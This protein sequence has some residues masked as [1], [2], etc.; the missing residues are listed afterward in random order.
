MKEEAA[1]FIPQL[2]NKLHPVVAHPGKPGG[3]VI[4]CTLYVCPVMMAYAEDQVN[5]NEKCRA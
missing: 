5:T 4:G 1:K 2:I 3:A